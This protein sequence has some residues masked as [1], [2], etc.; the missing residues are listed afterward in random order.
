MQLLDTLLPS[1]CVACRKVGR[2]ICDNCLAELDAKPRVV[3]RGIKGWSAIDYSATATSAINAFKEHGRTAL[4]TDFCRLIDAIDLPENAILVGL[5]SST[6]ATRKRGFVPAELLADRLARRRSLRSA[7][8][9]VFA[10]KIADQALLSR[11][12]RE[13]NLAGSMLAKPLGGPVILVDDVITT[14]ASMREAARAMVA[15]GNQVAGFI[16]IAETILK[17]DPS[18]KN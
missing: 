10:R 14:G 8:A 7:H 4:L 17:I 11:D 5:P 13:A 9:L 16:T 15:A 2:T 1:T 3:D 6:G 18:A 12:Q